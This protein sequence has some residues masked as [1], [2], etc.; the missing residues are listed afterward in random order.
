M[1]L[2]KRSKRQVLSLPPAVS[3][4]IKVAIKPHNGGIHAVA[5]AFMVPLYARVLYHMLP[6]YFSILGRILSQA[7]TVNDITSPQVL[8]DLQFSQWFQSTKYQ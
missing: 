4:V 6:V 3:M 1:Y 8:S 2:E 5:T 7:V